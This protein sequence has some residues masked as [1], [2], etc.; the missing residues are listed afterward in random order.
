[1][2]DVENGA[3]GAPTKPVKTKAPPSPIVP[4]AL[5]ALVSVRARLCGRILRLY[6]VNAA[7]ALAGA[8][9]S[10]RSAPPAPAPARASGRRRRSGS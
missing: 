8:V 7:P 10:R 9:R 2:T 4:K 6:A 3:N 1:M 5:A